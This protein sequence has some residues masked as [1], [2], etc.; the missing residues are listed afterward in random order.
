MSKQTI[1]TSKWLSSTAKAAIQHALAFEAIP[2]PPGQG[3]PLLGH[4]LMTQKP[5]G[6]GKAW[7][8]IK[9]MQQKY[10][11]EDDKL[12]RFISRVFNPK[13]GKCVILFDPQDVEHVYRH[14]GK[15]PNR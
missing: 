5:H 6:F 15:Y 9:E 14:E 3:L 8:N 4:T 11:K 7:L 10:S 13:T 12:M 2:G 1:I